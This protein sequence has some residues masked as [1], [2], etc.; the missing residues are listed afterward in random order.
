MADSVR[1]DAGKIIV[2]FS[3]SKR[4]QENI[5]DRSKLTEYA[6]VD[7]SSGYRKEMIWITRDGRRIAIPNLSD[8]HLLNII[9]YLQD[10]VKK[11]KM[12]LAARMLIGAMAQVMMFEHIPDDVLEGY[13]EESMNKIDNLKKM[14]NEDFLKKVFP[15]YGKLKEEA[16]RRKLTVTEA[17]DLP[18]PERA[19]ER[20]PE[21]DDVN[22]GDD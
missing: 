12:K 11:Y 8:S 13:S 19:L 5:K 7:L 17:N 2:D 1:E 9:S 16:Y 3:G 20:Y 14:P 4:T 6:N 10:R 21:T 15:I 22:Y 18:E